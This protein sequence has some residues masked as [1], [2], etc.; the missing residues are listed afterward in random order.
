MNLQVRQGSLLQFAPP[1]LPQILEWPAGNGAPSPIS[2]FNLSEGVSAT[3]AE[4]VEYRA[5]LCEA[6]GDF[7]GAADAYRML[8]R[9][10]PNP[11]VHLVLGAVYFKLGEYQRSA[12]A[13]T[14]SIA[15]L[16]KARR[17]SWP[18]DPATEFRA[19][20]V[21]ALANSVMGRTGPALAAVVSAIR[22]S[23]LDAAV[24]LLS[25]HI[26]EQAGHLETAVEEYQETIRLDALLTDPYLRLANLEACLAGR[27]A[28]ESRRREHLE[29]AIATYQTFFDRFQNS[30]SSAAHNNFGVLLSRVGNH[31]AAIDEYD[32][33]VKADPQNLVGA[34]N[35]GSAYLVRGQFEQAL[36]AYE[37]AL[38]VWENL[39]EGASYEQASDIF[40]GLG[41]ALAKLYEQSTEP[42][43]EVLRRAE[44]ALLRAI[45][46]DP[47]NLDA[48][49]NLGTIYAT[50]WR[51]DEAENQ[52]SATL[53]FDSQNRYAQEALSDIA[54]RRY[55]PGSA[56]DVKDQS[57]T[58]QT[59]RGRAILREKGDK[60]EQRE[61]SARM[62]GG[63]EPPRAEVPVYKELLR[64]SGRKRKL[65]ALLMESEW[66]GLRLVAWTR[67][68]GQCSLTQLASNV[69]AD[70]DCIAPL[71]ARLVGLGAIDVEDCR[72]RC[73]EQ[74][75][76]VLA[77]LEQTT[78]MDLDPRESTVGGG[79]H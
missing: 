12:S 40:N 4:Q 62:N 18:T 48:H 55:S 36:K 15:A 61:T 39:P 27:V 67:D 47:H 37:L 49:N 33:A 53:Q 25:G 44:A 19:H 64:E 51:L 46:L 2:G 66:L 41:M 28:N 68:L 63:I 21:L 1:P 11:E 78:G 74:G 59:Q 77:N 6:S 31:E 50:E 45:E 58:G 20:Y 56:R 71:L 70:V 13:M 8:A 52:F 57:R 79:S 54:T 17:R 14:R 60:E 69:T 7:R 30:A 10:M 65:M 34:A 29:R 24:H 38:T 22:L 3:D 23:P 72:F 9:M 75:L 5:R 42:D 76:S 73:T 32:A 43:A 16:R 26:Q 35:L